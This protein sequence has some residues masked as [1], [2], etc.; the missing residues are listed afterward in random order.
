MSTGASEEAALA[1]VPSL[2]ISGGE[3]YRGLGLVERESALFA[4][5]DAGIDDCSVVAGPAAVA[6]FG[7][8]EIESSC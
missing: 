7:E 4:E 2:G 3:S 1:C 8:R 5:V 6:D